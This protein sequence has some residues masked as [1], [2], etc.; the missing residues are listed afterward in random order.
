MLQPLW[1][2]GDRVPDELYLPD[3]E[4]DDKDDEDDEDD[5][6]ENGESSDDDNITVL[7]SNMIWH[8]DYFLH[9]IKLPYWPLL[10]S[11]KCPKN[12]IS[13]IYF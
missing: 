11:H 2:T 12:L 4:E 10:L 9:L 6:E 3:E 1:F 13:C 8:L 5:D 7:R